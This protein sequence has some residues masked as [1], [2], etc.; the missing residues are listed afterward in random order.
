MGAPCSRGEGAEEGRGRGL[1]EPSPWVW[2]WE[3]PYDAHAGAAR[4]AMQLGTRLQVSSGG[5]CRWLTG[6]GQAA[7]GV[8]AVLGASDSAPACACKDHQPPLLHLLQQATSY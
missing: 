1:V 6:Q 7:W 5:A 8:A 2:V 3:Q 4:R